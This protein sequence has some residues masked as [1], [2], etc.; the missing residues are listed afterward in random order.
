M[1]HRE[2]FLFWINVYYP[3]TSQ[4][5]IECVFNRRDDFYRFHGDLSH[6]T[7]TGGLDGASSNKIRLLR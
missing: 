6:H 5:M 4:I 3:H 1:K 7:L 2:V